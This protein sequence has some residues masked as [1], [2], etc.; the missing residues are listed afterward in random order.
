MVRLDLGGCASEYWQQ[1]KLLDQRFMLP[2]CPSCFV[3]QDCCMPPQV[4]VCKWRS[5]AVGCPGFSLL[6]AFYKGLC[7]KP[8]SWGSYSLEL[9]QAHAHCFLARCSLCWDLELGCMNHGDAVVVRVTR[10]CTWL[11][12]VFPGSFGNAAA[13]SQNLVNSLD[14]SYLLREQERTGKPSKD[15]IQ[16]DPAQADPIQVRCLGPACLF[17]QCKGLERCCPQITAIVAMACFPLG[18]YALALNECWKHSGS[19]TAHPR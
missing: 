10:R 8:R 15:P 3:Q 12:S 19:I 14:R 2:R 6:P 11:L 9:F 17:W 4:T 16:V 5:S 13:F 7:Q 18:G 1:R